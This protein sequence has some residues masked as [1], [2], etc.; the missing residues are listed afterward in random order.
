LHDSVTMTLL[1]RVVDLL[2]RRDIPHALIGAAA[3]AARGVA[4]ST[5]DID[6]LTTDAG[7][8]EHEWWT[9]LA[10]GDVTVDVRCGDADDPLAGIVRIETPAD[11]P[12]DLVVGRHAWQARAVARAERASAGPPVVTPVDLILLKLY[13]GG[14]QDVWDVREL[15]RQ[16]GAENLPAEV[17]A[18]LTSL[19][20]SMRDTWAD[21]R[22]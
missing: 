7:V 20:R 19:P 2:V 13:A 9:P 17:E 16:P 21:A 5:F 12:V 3:L 18:E 4:R 8:L 15:L 11:R 1:G 10:V 6:L 22:R 14:A